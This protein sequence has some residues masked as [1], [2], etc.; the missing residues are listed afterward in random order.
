[1]ALGIT[2]KAIKYYLRALALAL[3]LALAK[4]PG[5]KSFEALCKQ[6]KQKGRV[7]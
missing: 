6:K 5:F 3:A 1:V 7:G 2:K 4:A